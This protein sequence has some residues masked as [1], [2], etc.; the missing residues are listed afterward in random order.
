VREP[1]GGAISFLI[2][3]LEREGVTDSGEWSDTVTRE[4]DGGGE[5]F[6]N[7]ASHRSTV[8]GQGRRRQRRRVSILLATLFNITI[9]TITNQ[10]ILV[11][12][13]ADVDLVVDG[14]SKLNALPPPTGLLKSIPSSQQPTTREL[15]TT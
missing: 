6:N 9:L 11:T 8:R 7:D 14:A 15:S 13:N 4:R 2:I 1:Q 3:V 10:T 12:I 5:V